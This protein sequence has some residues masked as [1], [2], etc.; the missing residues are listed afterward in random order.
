MDNAGL[1]PIR[2]YIGYDPR[3]PVAFQVLAHS[4][5]EHASAPVSI[6]RLNL[7][8]LPLTR[9]GLTEFTYSRFMVPWLSS[10]E[11][12]SI[13]LDSDCLC[14][15]DVAEL[16]AYPMAY[17]ETAVFVSQNKLRFEWASVMVFNNAQC[18]I[19]TP[20]YVQEKTHP[21]FDFAWAPQVGALQPLWNHLVGY[22]DPNPDAKLVH[23]TQGIPCWA[24]T[25]DCEHAQGWAQ[26]AKR[27]ISTVSFQE[28][29]GKSVHIAA[30]KKKVLA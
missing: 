19:L 28:L 10:Y 20:D 17:P 18:R 13:F 3:Q 11:G 5:W 1:T 23:Y 29:M 4:V 8:T 9:R 12:T 16:L 27:A 7:K 25:K 24:E 2:V 15:S 22:D 30:M 14:R 6:T 26:T 21:L